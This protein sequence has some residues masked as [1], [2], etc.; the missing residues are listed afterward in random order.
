MPELKKMCELYLKNQSVLITRVL[1]SISVIMPLNTDTRS[2]T[3]MKHHYKTKSMCGIGLYCPCIKVTPVII[4][5]YF[6]FVLKA[7][8]TKE[9]FRFVL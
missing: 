7:V 2:Y 3:L 5:E 9:I 6:R 1:Y 4:K 8:I